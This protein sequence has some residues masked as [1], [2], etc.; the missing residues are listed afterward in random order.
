MLGFL[1]LCFVVSSIHLAFL[2]GR[3][4][5]KL[6]AGRALLS[7]LLR[8]FRGVGVSAASVETLVAAWV[9]SALANP[10]FWG[11]SPWLCRRLRLAGECR[12]RVVFAGRV[13]KEGI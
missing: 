11:V 7:R 1:E 4:W 12:T 2:L 8:D 13:K 5:G 6:E 3:E 10:E 9:R